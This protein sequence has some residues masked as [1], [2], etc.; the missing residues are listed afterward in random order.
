[1]AIKRTYVPSQYKNWWK[2]HIFAAAY[3]NYN[4]QDVLELIAGLRHDWGAEQINNFF[5]GIRN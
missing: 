2:R 4:A 5:Y 3:G 1:M